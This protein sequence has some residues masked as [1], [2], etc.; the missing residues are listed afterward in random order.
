MRLIVAGAG[1]AGLKVVQIITDSH[2]A[3]D[4]EYEIAAFIDDSLEKGSDFYGYPVIGGTSDLDEIEETIGP[5]DTLG[6]VCAIGE[7]RIRRKVL[8]LI[9]PRF[10]IFPNLIHPSAQ[11]SKFASV[12]KGNVISQNVVVQPEALVGDFNV[13]KAGVAVGSY[14]KITEYC[15][16][17]TNSITQC[18]A[19]LLPGSSMGGG[20]LVIEDVTLGERSHVGPNSLLTRDLDADTTV[21]GVPARRLR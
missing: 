17:G 12:G 11:V 15:T 19:T 2:D 13:I 7:P 5:L 21:L 4:R 1:N 8:D 18:R 9:S 3:G 20:A 6:L 14:S 16:M 10:K